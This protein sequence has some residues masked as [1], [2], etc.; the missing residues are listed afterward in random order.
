M[1]NLTQRQEA[2][3][4]NLFKGLTQRESWIQAGYSSNYALS[5]VDR[6]ACV[7]ANTTKIKQRLEELRVEARTADVADF[8]ERQRILS[9]ITRATIP[10]YVTEEGIKV[11]K[12]SPNVRAVSEI[13]TRTKIF[14]RNGEPVNI[15]NL[16]LHNPISAID[17]LNKMDGLYSDIPPVRNLSI[18]FV[19]GKGYSD[20]PQLTERSNNATE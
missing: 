7:M 8:Q 19:I 2:F 9:E 20:L 13:T 10:D 12:Q 5:N 14:R 6:N 1:A 15:T 4:L 11:N 3:T 16:K 17:L 18:V